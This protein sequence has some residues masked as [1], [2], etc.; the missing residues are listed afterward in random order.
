MIGELRGEEA[1]D[2]ILDLQVEDIL[3]LQEAAPTGAEVRASPD[4]EQ[5]AEPR[6]EL[7]VTRRHR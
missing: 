7:I 4:A 6:A 3:R 1:L 5:H 2:A